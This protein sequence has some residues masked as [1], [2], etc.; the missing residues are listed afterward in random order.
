MKILIKNANIITLGDDSQYLERCS[1]IIEGNVIKSINDTFL[2]DEDSFDRVLD[3]QNKIVMPGYINAHTH[4]YSSFAKGISGIESSANFVEVLNNM[5]WK[6]DKNL[7]SDD[8]YYSAKTA[9]LNGI[10][11]GVTTFI[12]HHAS[13]FAITGSLGRIG[14][15]ITECGVKGC[16]CYEISDRDG[17][18]KSNEGVEES[19][20][21]IEENKN[22]NLK[23]LIGLHASFTVSD[24]T[25]E[26]ISSLNSS[27][28]GYHIHVSE[29][30]ADEKDSQ[31]KY[32]TSVI[33]RLNKHGVLSPNTI[34]AHCVH[35]SDEDM[36][37]IKE[38]N[39]MVVHNP[40]S[41]ANN[42]V[43]IG[44]VVSLLEKDIL[45]GLGTDAM[46]NRMGQEV[47]VGL[48]L[49]HLRG[50]NPSCGF[51]EMSQLLLNNNAKIVNRLWSDS[52][53]GSVKEG[54]I[55]D[56]IILDYDP[57]TPLSTD[58]QLGHIIFGIA[59]APV[60]TTIANGNVLWH[61]GEFENGV[62]E[63]EVNKQSRK[64]AKELWERM[65]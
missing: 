34:L 62:D 56:L 33:Q 53:T 5:W 52:T 8:V 12:D 63:H 9:I 26:K 47:R 15:A 27:K 55:A 41:N 31:D 32:G 21:F 54:N 3:A 37:L 22:P 64:L 49:Q 7:N 45:V 61:K 60:E 36:L 43:G 51:M 38:S 10:K 50:E 65:K 24:E 59:E 46:T 17:M 6:L 13:P 20:S 48:W 25:L 18:E 28:I 23:G 1:I 11:N 57:I 40:Q 39:S 58:N 44:D 2:F 14:E 42:A 30:K 19:F 29:D 16:L 4:F 35:V